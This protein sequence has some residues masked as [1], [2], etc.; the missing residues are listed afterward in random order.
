MTERR[1]DPLDSDYAEMAAD[2]ER[3]AEALAWIEGVLSV[4]DEEEDPADEGFT[5]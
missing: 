2:A 4:P 3:E 5:P 1:R